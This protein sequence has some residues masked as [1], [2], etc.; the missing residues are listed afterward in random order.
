MDAEHLIPAYEDTLYYLWAEQN[1]PANLDPLKADLKDDLERR[2]IAKLLTRGLNTE[3]G[4][5][6]PIEWNYVNQRWL[7]GR[8]KLRNDNLFLIPGDS[9][10]GLRLPLNSLA[11]PQ[12]DYERYQPESDPLRSRA[13]LAPSG[14]QFANLAAQKI[15]AQ[16][17]GSNNNIEKHS[18]KN[19]TH[20]TKPNYIEAGYVIRTAMCFEAR[21]GRLHL[22]LPPL[23]YLEHYV[24]LIEAIEDTAATLNMPVVLEGYE[25]P[26]DYRLKD[27]L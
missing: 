23:T 15:T 13:P 3:S 12:H 9:P 14:Q 10:L 1:L 7:T 4:Y 20:K 19:P 17:I 18:E 26:K 16:P 8:W 22:F 24:A 6:L 5:V 27:C 25:P 21:D 11:F 2:R